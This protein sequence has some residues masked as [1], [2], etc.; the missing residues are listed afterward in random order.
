MLFRR[1]DKGRFVKPDTPKE[2]KVEVTEKKEEKVIPQFPQRA[3]L[4][5]K[6]IIERQRH[7][8]I[9]HTFESEELAKA[10]YDNNFADA[11]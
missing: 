7:V 9:K 2:E 4:D 11:V 5:G 3:T 10:Y 6:S 8:I 1:V